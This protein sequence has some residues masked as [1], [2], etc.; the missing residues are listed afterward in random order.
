[1]MYCTGGVRCEQASSYLLSKDVAKEVIQLKG[2]ICRYLERFEGQPGFFRGKNFVFDYRRYEP[3]HDGSVVGKCDGCNQPWDDYDNG[4]EARCASCRVL[5]LLCNTCRASRSSDCAP[6]CTSPLQPLLCGGTSCTG[7][8]ICCS[9]GCSRECTAGPIC[10]RTGYFTRQAPKSE[11]EAL[12][13]SQQTH[14]A[15]HVLGETGRNLVSTL[16]CCSCLRAPWEAFKARFQVR[17]AGG[18]SKIV[19]CVREAT[20]ADVEQCLQIVNEA[21]EVA[22][23]TARYR[24]ALTVRE[25]ARQQRLLVACGDDG[26]V[27]GCAEHETTRPSQTLTYG[28]VAVRPSVQC[29]GVGAELIAEIERRAATEGCSAVRVEVR[30]GAGAQGD[31]AVRFYQ[32]HGYKPCG[33]R[34]RNYITLGKSV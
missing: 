4:P 21:F 17:L 14:T 28:P 29:K 3:R 1:M 30:R 11:S 20:D 22:Y 16:P 6:G 5:L 15:G 24:N 31:R 33:P 12:A 26:V 25:A 23:G 7:T 8:K 27:M 2:G 34:K 10:G 18:P 32:R 13:A 19:S 9:C